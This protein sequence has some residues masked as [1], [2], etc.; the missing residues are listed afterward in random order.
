[1][2]GIF[3]DNGH[4]MQFNPTDS[5]KHILRGGSLMGK[6]RYGQAEH[7]FS[8]ILKLRIYDFF[9]RNY[10]CIKDQECQYNCLW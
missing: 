10:L 8:R 7:I 9:L 6:N 5:S 4:S 1:M 3:V 2:T